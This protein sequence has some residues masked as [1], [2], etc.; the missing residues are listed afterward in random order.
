MDKIQQLIIDTYHAKPKH[1]TQILKRN[2]EVL[3]YVKLHTSGSGSSSFLEQLYY[4]VYKD[5]NICPNGNI[6]QLKTFAGYSFCGKT[7]VCQCAKESV[8]KSVSSAKQNYTD[9]KNAAINATRAATNVLLYGVTNVGQ[10]VDAR[11]AHKEFYEDDNNVSEVTAQIKKTKLNAHGDENYNNRLKAEITCLEKYNVKNTWSL[12]A[13]KQNPNLIYLK[14]KEKLSQLFPRLS[15]EDIAES[16]SVHVQTVYHYLNM[17]KFRDPYKSTFE[18]EIIYYLET[19]GVVNIITNKRKLIGKELDIYL[20]DYKLAIEYNGIYWH[21][22]GIAH[23]TR[24][25]HYDKF[26]ACEKL[27]IELF[28]IFGDSW[29]DKKDI[30][31]EKIRAKLGIVDNTIFAR[32]TEI[33]SL[34][35]H[36][37]REILNNHHVQ[38]YSTSEICYGLKFN[39]EII[40]IMTFSKPRFGIGKDRGKD[41]YE[42]V[43][44]VTT[45]SVPGGASKLLAHFRKMHR[46]TI[47]YSY[48]NNMYSVGKLYK[49]LGFNLENEY[50]AGYW[51]F[52]PD[53]K[54]SYHRSNYTK[55]KLVKAG[56][57]GSQSE[58][59]IMYNRGFLRLWDCGMRTWVLNLPTL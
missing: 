13:D 34:M 41:S 54:R 27:G 5:S 31:K 43:R 3:A 57:D 19:L 59:E 50:K 53:K 7:S 4:C 42:L 9:D 25:Y 21:H 36:E 56:F 1:F 55:Y 6:K 20:P 58:S 44:Y 15:V 23:I 22:D 48:S 39:N 8:S 35:P 47:I 32:K 52:S 11:Q 46:P 17:H 10:T 45:C 37:T 30:W 26:T 2:S 16:L 12:R 38:G 28:S 29:K 51:Y 24:T 14:D 40:A 18:K 49:I 33:V